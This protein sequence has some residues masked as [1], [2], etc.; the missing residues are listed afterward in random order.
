MAEG[1]GHT[2]KV[3]SR[4]SVYITKSIWHIPVCFG[5]STT[6]ENQS[7]RTGIART[8]PSRQVDLTFLEKSLFRAMSPAMAK[9]MNDSIT[10]WKM[11]LTGQGR[12]SEIQTK[13]CSVNRKTESS[14]QGCVLAKQGKLSLDQQ[15]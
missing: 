12:W 10:F 14:N 8:L 2:S 7:S 1:K 9:N 3:I 6:K 5:L 4:S 15:E 11:G 13:N